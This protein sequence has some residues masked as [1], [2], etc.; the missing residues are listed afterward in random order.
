MLTNYL[1]S[2]P[3][4]IMCFVKQLPQT[5]MFCEKEFQSC[6][7]V[8]KSPQLVML[9]D[10]TSFGKSATATVR[11]AQGRVGCF[12]IHR[13]QGRLDCQGLAAALLISSS[14]TY[15]C[16]VVYM[17]QLNCSLLCR[18]HGVECRRTC[19]CIQSLHWQPLVCSA[20]CMVQPK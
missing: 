9:S 20:V 15:L 6:G 17:V 2:S 3:V 16:S 7:S 12:H 19:P 11:H 8:I 13:S 14:K 4:E 18:L 1:S 5:L 10:K